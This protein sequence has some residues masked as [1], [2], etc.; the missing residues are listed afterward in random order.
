MVAVRALYPNLKEELKPGR[1]VSVKAQLSEID[2]AVSIPSEA[3]IPEMEGEKVFVYK[4]GKAEQ[5]RISI[6]LRTEAQVQVRQGLEFGDTLLTTAT[7]QLRQ[8]AP[9]MLDTLVTNKPIEKP[10]L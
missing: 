10:E 2:N 8:G 9:V 4:G 5:R 1:F 6:G 3:V 7:L